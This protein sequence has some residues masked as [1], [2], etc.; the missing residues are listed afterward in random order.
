MGTDP[1]KSE[2]AVPPAQAIDRVVHEPARYLLMA[3]L[4]VIT[5]ADFLYLER[6]TGLTRGNL[7]F[8]LSKLEQSGYVE[9]EKGFTGKVPR[10]VVRLTKAGRD[11]FETYRTTMRNLLDG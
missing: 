11:A 7:S 9:I 6:Q 5:E 8:H 2:K 4:Y 10:T 1:A 3:H